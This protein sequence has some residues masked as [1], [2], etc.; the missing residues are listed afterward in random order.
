MALPKPEPRRSQPPPTHYLG[1]RGCSGKLWEPALASLGFSVI[2]FSALRTPSSQPPWVEDTTEAKGSCPGRPLTKPSLGP[3]L[4]PQKLPGK[5]QKQTTPWSVTSPTTSSEKQN[6][7]RTLW[8]CKQVASYLGLPEAAHWGCRLYRHQGQLEIWE[9]QC[10]QPC[11]ALGAEA[12]LPV[13]T[14]EALPRTRGFTRPQLYP[15]RKRFS[16]ESGFRGKGRESGREE[17]QR[18][19]WAIPSGQTPNIRQ[20]EML[21]TTLCAQSAIG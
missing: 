16:R 18:G 19:A 20:I 10:S 6:D 5:P 8:F 21:G 13:R 4:R 11:P 2:Q 12:L 14:R 3:Q 15:E 17:G 9:T 7:A 1:P